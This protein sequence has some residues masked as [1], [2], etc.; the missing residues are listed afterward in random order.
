MTRRV[1]IER[2]PSDFPELLVTVP[3]TWPYIILEPFYDVHLGNHLHAAKQFLRDVERIAAQRFTLSWNGGD[4]LENNVLGSPEV[5]G[6]DKPPE[7]QFAEA[8]ELIRPIL[9]KL[10]FAITGNHEARTWKVAGFSI[11]KML[12]EKM[13]LEYFPD[14]CFL[15]I[16]WRGNRFRGVIHHGSGASATPGGQRNAARKDMPWTKADFYWTG[17]L[18]Q[19][20]ADLIYQQEYNQR[21]NRLHTRQGLVI[22]SPSYVKYYGGYAAAKRLGPGTL[23]TTPIRLYPDGTVEAVIRAKGRRL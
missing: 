1:T 3:D 18:H 11:A 15:T 6:Q 20:M 8:L 21:T 17:H 16:M 2:P 22:I 5:F 13:G 10:L 14:Y 23:G 7:G 19:A 9:P 12:A 4:L